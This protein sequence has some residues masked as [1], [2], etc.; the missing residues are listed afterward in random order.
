MRIPDRSR[1]LRVALS[2]RAQYRPK[3]TRLTQLPLKGH[4]PPCCMDQPVDAVDPGPLVVSCDAD[5]ARASQLQHTVQ[6]ADSNCDFTAMP[7]SMTEP[8]T[9][10]KL[11]IVCMIRSAASSPPRYRMNPVVRQPTDIHVAGIA[12]RFDDLRDKKQHS[13]LAVT[14]PSA[15]LIETKP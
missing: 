10:A 14:R 9:P 7:T 2:G 3:P 1:A 4:G 13:Q 12:E 6:D 11:P 15:A 5:V 8:T